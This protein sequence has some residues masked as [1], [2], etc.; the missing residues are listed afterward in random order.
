MKTK[1][2]VMIVSAMVI[3]MTTLMLIAVVGIMWF[4][5]TTETSAGASTTTLTTEP[6]DNTPRADFVYLQDYDTQTLQRINLS[7]GTSQ[8]FSLDLTLNQN[9]YVR[10]MS[11]SDDGRLLAFCLARVE[12]AVL[13]E[14]RFIVREIATETNLIDQSLGNIVACEA[15]AFNAQGTLVGLGRVNNSP[16]EGTLNFPDLPNWSLQLIDIASGAVVQEL[17][18][19]DPNAPD[20]A[21]MVEDFWFQ[22]GISPMTLV[23]WFDEREVVFTAYPYIGRDG[24]LRVPAHRWDLQTGAVTPVEGLTHI[25]ADYLRTTDEIAYPMLDESQPYTLPIGPMP[26]ANM[27]MIGRDGN[28]Q[29]IYRNGDAILTEPRFIAGGE[30]IAL[31]MLPGV[32]EGNFDQPI[33][34]P[35]HIIVGRDGQAQQVNLGQ[36]SYPR[37]FGTADGMLVFN[38]DQN[39]L[40]T[41][42]YELLRYVNGVTSTV[43]QAEMPQPSSLNIV[44]AP[45]MPART[46][47]TP[48]VPVQ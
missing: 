9:S 5:T 2:V 45:P 11:F 40:S 37:L 10:R 26:I 12:E 32:E 39:D 28:D 29:V 14:Q 22:D 33:D 4:S 23:E 1:K 35:Y 38:I 18:A 48:F 16:L 27:L 21:S 20:Y 30:Q 34:P 44:W 6:A 42:R 46:D 15:S 13:V 25:G 36:S 47:L 7:D 19:S 41:A 31:T 3:G 24:P 43:W 17:N 8:T